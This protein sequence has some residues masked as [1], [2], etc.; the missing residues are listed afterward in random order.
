MKICLHSPTICAILSAIR[1]FL[2]RGSFLAQVTAPWNRYWTYVSRGTAHDI[3]SVRLNPHQDWGRCGDPFFCWSLDHVLHW[4]SEHQCYH[5][6][7]KLRPWM[8]LGILP[9]GVCQNILPTWLRGW[10]KL[11]VWRLG[12]VVENHKKSWSQIFSVLIK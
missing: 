1:I 4:R 12:V 8:L 9:L 3:D 11:R 6:L 7:R 10:H 2:K 5:L